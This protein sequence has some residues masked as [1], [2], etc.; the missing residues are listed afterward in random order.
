MLRVTQK[1]L[2]EGMMVNKSPRGRIRFQE[3]YLLSENKKY[4]NMIVISQGMILK[5]RH[6]KEDHLISGIKVSFMVIFFIVLSL[7]I[8]L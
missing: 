2:K 5:G 6:H 8:K 4:S 3:Y 1:Y 7:D